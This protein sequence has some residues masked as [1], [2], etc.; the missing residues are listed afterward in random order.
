ME[1]WSNAPTL[2]YNN[3]LERRRQD[4]KIDEDVWSDIAGGCST[5]FGWGAYHGVDVLSEP[6]FGRF[7]DTL[8]TD[9]RLGRIPE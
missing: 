3:S 4:E 9:G 1:R 8:G 6:L 7:L 2:P 5:G